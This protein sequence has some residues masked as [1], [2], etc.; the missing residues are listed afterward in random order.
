VF[1][2]AL[3]VGYGIF[4]NWRHFTTARLLSEAQDATTLPQGLSALHRLARERTP[5]LTDIGRF[6]LETTERSPARADPRTLHEILD[7][8]II[9]LGEAV[10]QNPSDILSYRTL[11][12]LLVRKAKL[13]RESRYF[14]VA[15]RALRAALRRAPKFPSLYLD[16]G[17][18]AVARGEYEQAIQDG[19]AAIRLS[20]RFASAWWFVGGV[21]YLRGDDARAVSSFDRAFELG[22]NRHW[23]V[24]G[25]L[26]Q[27]SVLY[28]RVKRYKETVAFLS[29]LI[30]L[31]PKTPRYYLTLAAVYK[32]EGDSQRARETAQRLLAI[33]PTLAI[34]Q[35]GK[36]A[37][38]RSARAF[39]LVGPGA[40]GQ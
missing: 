24:I 38:E 5:F 16:L 31:D 29:R 6:S 20:P 9:R 35:E 11:A 2:V 18:V 22:H 13:T 27:L 34:T 19:E 40:Q 36:A 17:A 4:L 26:E 10:E 3:A 39:L 8:G 28:H 21:S 37:L 25:A 23:D 14:D 33:L 12:G 15:E 7:L 30:E 1:F 32:E